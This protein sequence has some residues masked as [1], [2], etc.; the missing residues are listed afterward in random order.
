M[1][2]QAPARYTPENTPFHGSAT[3]EVT[4]TLPPDPWWKDPWKLGLAA[5]AGV[6]F[7][8]LLRQRRG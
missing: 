8:V 1:A 3:V 5:T 4:D 6:L 2:D 7:L